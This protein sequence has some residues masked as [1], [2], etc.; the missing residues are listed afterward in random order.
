MLQRI[1][2]ATVESPRRSA[3]AEYYPNEAFDAKLKP[4]SEQ[5]PDASQFLGRGHGFPRYSLRRL[6]RFQ[7]ARKHH[8]ESGG[9]LE[10]RFGPRV[11]PA[12]SKTDFLERIAALSGQIRPYSAKAAA[13]AIMSVCVATALRFAAG[14][15][16]IDPGFSLYVAA[17]LATGLLAGVPAAIGAAASSILIVT[18]AFTP[19]YF[20]FSWPSFSDQVLA[21]FNALASVVTICFAQCCRVVLQR[22][23]TREL[24]NEML[25]N[26]LNHRGRNL[27]SI[28]QLIVRKSLLDQQQR[29]DEILGRLGAIH[30]ANELLTSTTGMPCTIS[31]LVSH[32]F[33]A[34]G[35]DR[36]VMRGPETVIEPGVGRDLLLLFHELATNAA[37]YG[38]LSRPG[39]RV[40]VEWRCSGCR[41]ALTWKESGGPPVV[42]PNRQG[43]GSKLIATCLTALG[44]TI[45]S[46]FSPEGYSC[47]MNFRAEKYR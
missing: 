26:E 42:P 19:P 24:T 43:F 3:Q 45:E 5:T 10:D 11:Q 41:V 4:D 27:F 7:K 21:A 47:R 28:T 29:A 16:L 25:V 9:A 18:W 38:A 44:G 14:R 12:P 2:G 39:G 34:Y 13:I 36:V 6:V 31:S 32:E 22:M 8:S 46:Q 35:E 40:L 30:R 15:A 33:A 1:G 20:V 17:I 37:K 23:R